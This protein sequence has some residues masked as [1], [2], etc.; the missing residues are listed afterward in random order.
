MKSDLRAWG[1][2]GQGQIEGETGIKI[3]EEQTS[4]KELVWSQ[5]DGSAGTG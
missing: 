5:G 1:R 2:V 3:M 4:P